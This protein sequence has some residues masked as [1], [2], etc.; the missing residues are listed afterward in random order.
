MELVHA[1]GLANRIAERR[2]TIAILSYVRVTSDGKTV[3]LTATDLDTEARSVVA[4]AGPKFD[5]C[6]PADALVAAARIASPVLEQAQTKLL[7][8]DDPRFTLNTLPADDFPVAKMEKPS[9]AFSLNAGQF[10]ADLRALRRA[11]STDDTRYY[12]NGIYFHVREDK[13]AMAATDGHRLIRAT[14]PVPMGA[15]KLGGS[16]LRSRAVDMILAAFEA[17]PEIRQLALEFEG[18][19]AR[20]IIGDITI[21]TKLIDGVYPDYTRVIP[22]KPAGSIALR[23]ADLMALCDAIISVGGRRQF[24]ELNFA[25]NEAR[26]SLHEHGAMAAK[27]SGATAGELPTNIGF[28]ATY[29]REILGT[30]P[31]DTFTLGL[32]G[33]ADPALFTC[34]DPA[35]TAVLMPVRL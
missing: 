13:L 20:L 22:T 29:L 26:A 3:T 23:A 30:R 11:V 10:A 6:A 34:A 4:I 31:D 16:I 12:L 18:H 19:T 8:G 14:R 24:L 35:F 1:A 2:S 7:I 21:M 15:E 5:T 28:N 27:L 33:P 32:S 9:V 25:R 17:Q